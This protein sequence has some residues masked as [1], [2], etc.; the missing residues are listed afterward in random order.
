MSGYDSTKLAERL[1]LAAAALGFVREALIWPQRVAF[2]GVV[3]AALLTVLSPALVVALVLAVTRRG[4]RLAFAA[5][6]VLTALAWLT[7]MKLGLTDGGMA[8]S[9]GAASL[10]TGT[11]ALAFMAVALWQRRR[12][13]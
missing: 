8:F 11:L 13:P 3:L 4:S 5:I 12:Q 7:T 2:D 9:I 6:V 1:G 10:I